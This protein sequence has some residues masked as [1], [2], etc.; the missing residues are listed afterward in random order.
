MLPIKERKKKKNQPTKSHLY[1]NLGWV[2]VGKTGD[3]G[4]APDLFVAMTW[5]KALHCP[6]SVI[7]FENKTKSSKNKQIKSIKRN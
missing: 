7:T 5:G 4:P 2:G 1:Q 6:L 3:Q